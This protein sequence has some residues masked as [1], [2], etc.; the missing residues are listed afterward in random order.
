MQEADRFGAAFEVNRDV[1]LFIKFDL[2]DIIDA[3]GAVNAYEQGVGKAESRLIGFHLL[4]CR[5]LGGLALPDLKYDVL[6]EHA[7]SVL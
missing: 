4:S 5:F 2:G 1:A 7:K 6:A 3:A